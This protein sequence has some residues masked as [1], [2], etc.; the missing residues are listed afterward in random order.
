MNASRPCPRCGELVRASDRFC[1]ACGQT[2]TDAGPSIDAG[3]S[4]SP[5]T[6][7]RARLLERLRRV[8]R[9]VYDIQGEI[10]RGG[11][12]IVYMAEDLKLGRRVAI[13][14]MRPSLFMSEG[15][16]DRFR[17]EA[18]TAANLNH[19]NIIT[20]HAVEQA[21]DL[22]FFVMQL[23]DGAPLDR[24][25]AHAGTLSIQATRALLIEVSSALHYAHQAG[26]VH[27]DVKPSNV[28]LTT[29]GNAIVTDFGIAKVAASSQH[30]TSTGSAIGTPAYMSPEQCMGLPVSPA[31]DQYSLGIMAYELIV[32]EPPFTGSTL[33]VQWAHAKQDPPPLTQR[34]SSVPHPLGAAVMRTL[35]KKPDDRFADLEEF[36]LAIREGFDPYDPGPRRELSQRVQNVGRIEDSFTRTTP[37]AGRIPSPPPEVKRTP[38]PPAPP[39]EP[40]VIEHDTQEIEVGERIELSAELED[41]GSITWRSS[42]PAILTVTTSGEVVGC[43]LGRAEAIAEVEGQ[44]I[45]CPFVVTRARIVRVVAS[46]DHLSAEAGESLP[47]PALSLF[48]ARNVSLDGRASGVVWTTSDPSRAAVDQRSGSVRAVSAGPVTLS[49]TVEDVTVAVGFVIRPAAVASLEAV[50]SSLSAEV[51]DQVPLPRVTTRDTRKALL[52]GREVLWR[53]ETPELLAAPAMGQVRALAAGKGVLVAACEGRELA[54]PVAVKVPAVKRL[55]VEPEALAGDAGAWL[56]L[57]TVRARAANGV[58][59]EGAAVRWTVTK[60]G[61]AVV[62]G[63]RVKLVGPGQAVLRAE[64]G[65]VKAEVSVTVRAIAAPPAEQPKA[66]P[67]VAPPPAAPP[68]EDGGR[69]VERPLLIADPPPPR[70]E[71]PLILPA[72]HHPDPAGPQ[73][74]PK[75]SSSQTPKIA[76]GLGAVAVVAIGAFLLTREPSAPRDTAPVVDSS[77]VSA[78][79]DSNS[80]PPTSPVGTTVE[81]TPAPKPTVAPLPAPAPSVPSP[82]P[83]SNT[84]TKAV[85]TLSLS[86]LANPVEVGMQARLTANYQSPDRRGPAE[87]RWNSLSPEIAAVDGNGLVTGLAPGRATIQATVASVRAT[88]IVTVVS[89][90]PARIDVSLERSSV[91]VGEATSV[92]VAVMAANGKVIDDASFTLESFPPDLATVTGTNALLGRFPGQVTV[93]ARAGS[94]IGTTVLTVVPR[95]AAPAPAAAPPTAPAGP[96]GA[97]REPTARRGSFPARAEVERSV[98]AFVD[99]IRKQQTA[100]ALGF[101][102]ASATGRKEFQT[103]LSNRE[104]TSV[105]GTPDLRYNEEEGSF[106][107]GITVTWVNAAGLDREKSTSLRGRVLTGGRIEIQSLVLP[108]P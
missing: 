104:K 49:A 83:G 19:P 108:F 20:I 67:P 70:F 103:W 47:L 50:P 24:V 45:R 23:V 98:F 42:D 56:P 48:D 88:T 12:A 102:A 55:E 91:Q 31:A 34:I 68:S 79:V 14:L 44:V 43:G 10:G 28:M 73:A 2:V 101:F 33:E 30:L 106:S 85:A 64:L 26:V 82:V 6:T 99:A 11:M 29:R 69:V 38:A 96:A 27:R 60:R 97:A 9:N 18:R 71:A 87:T 40:V 13:K 75:A 105:Q 1:P 93:R 21:D 80:A 5:T 8:T 78:P 81:R 84:N 3:F 58:V 36:I 25:I 22:L 90:A 51:G 54:V 89:P 94:A 4:A 100:A 59:L 37:D 107:L 57:P 92:R 7:E 41:G 46:P 76:L 86:S 72:K 77:A 65:P 52:E 95:P 74:D 66:T 53:S 32:G 62:E 39:P 16:E 35:A 17:L 61:V 15:M 63:N